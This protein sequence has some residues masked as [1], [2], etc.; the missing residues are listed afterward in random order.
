MRALVDQAGLLPNRQIALWPYTSWDDPRLQPHDDFILV[1]A[2][3]KMPP[4][5]IGYT[6]NAAWLGYLR[7]GIFFCKKCTYQTGAVYPDFGSNTECYCDD[8]FIELETLG[9]LVSLEPGQ[10]TTHVET[11]ELYEA[12]GVPATRTGLAEFIKG[13]GLP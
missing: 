2:C 12:E 3:E 8:R 6:N 4:V 13:L 11:W 9:P 7:Q 5:K 10:S 1:Q